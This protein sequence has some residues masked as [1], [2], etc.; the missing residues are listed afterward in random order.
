MDSDG[1]TLKSLITFMKDA[2]DACD[3][4][5]EVY[6]MFDQIVTYLEED[7]KP[8]VGLKFTTRILGL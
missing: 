3:D 1:I 2:R 6:F 5:E 7:Y 8:S 4:N